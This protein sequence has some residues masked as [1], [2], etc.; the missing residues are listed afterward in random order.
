MQVVIGD[1]CRLDPFSLAGPGLTLQ[2]GE[3]LPA[4][5]AKPRKAAPGRTSKG[6]AAAAQKQSPLMAEALTPIESPALTAY[7]YSLLQVEARNSNL[8]PNVYHVH[9]AY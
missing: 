7:A 4:L 5:A 9:R 2:K 6:P 8:N 3:Q 1:S